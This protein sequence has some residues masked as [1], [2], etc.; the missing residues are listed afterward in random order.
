MY[1]PIQNDNY[2][3]WI[4]IFNP[5]NKSINISGWS[6]SDNFSNDTIEGDFDNF[7]GSTIIPAMSYAIIADHGTKIY[8][9]FSIPNSTTCLY[10]DDKS[11]GNGLGNNGDKL[12]LRNNKSEIIDSVK[13]IENYSDITGKTIKKVN[14][15][16][17]ICRFEKEI[18]NKTCEKYYEGFIPT[19]GKKNLY[20]QGQ[21]NITIETQ[22]S[23]YEVK[24][25]KIL[26]IPLK[27]KNQGFIYDNITLVI[28]KLS[29]NWNAVLKDENLS[30]YPNQ[31][32]KVILEI[33]PK[34]NIA[35]MSGY[36]EILALSEKEFGNNDKTKIY[37]ELSAPDL[38]IKKIKTYNEKNIEKNVFN[39]GEII[40]VKAFLKNFGNVNVSNIKAEFYINSINNHNYMG[41][42]YYDLVSK[43][44][45]YPSIK[46]DT[47]TLKPGIHTIYVLVDKKQE[48]EETNESNNFLTF[49]I[50]IFNTTP[51]IFSKNIVISE[52]YYHSHPGLFNEYIA[53][54]NPTN[55]II[56]ISSFYLTNNPDK[57]KTDQRKIIFPKNTYIKNKSYLFISENSKNFSFEKIEKPD[58]EYNLD[59][60]LSIPQMI[61]KNKFIM[62]NNGCSIALKN[63]FNHTI[64]FLTYG[65]N[66]YNSSFWKGKAINLTGKG[67]ILKRN[68]NEK[69]LPYDTDTYHDWVQDRKYVIGQ[70][71]FSGKT[72]HI[73]DNITTFISPDN[74]FNAIVNEL[75]KAKKSIYLNVYEFTSFY[76]CNELVKNL[77][78]NVSVTIFLEGAPVGGI[79]EEEKNILNK[80]DSN[81]G[82]IR[83]IV[84]NKDKKIYSRYPFNHAK[85]CIIDN[86]TTII[87]SCN[88]VD[89]GIPKNNKYGNREWGIIIKNEEI[90]KYF[91]RIF[92][93]DYN[94][95]R[96]DSISFFDMNFTFSSD[97]YYQPYY[98]GNYKSVFK[99]NETS[100]NFTIKTVISP[101]NSQKAILDLLDSANNSIYIQ[102]LYIY[103]NWSNKINPFV[104]K[105]ID[106]SK[107]GL[108]IRVIL[109]Y[110]P[111]YNDTNKKVDNTKKLLEDNN[112]K[113]RYI[114]TTW[115][116]FTNI[117]NKGVIVDNESVLISSINWNE[118]SVLNNREI[119]VIIKNKETAEYYTNVFLYDWNL[120]FE[121]NE[122]INNS[123]YNKSNNNNNYFDNYENNIYI[124]II[125]TLT[126]GLIIQDWR[127]R[128]WT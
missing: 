34:K 76:L 55:C 122:K 31:S 90:A 5:S 13:W 2:N 52:I 59:S 60:D 43:Y 27:I 56:N 111:V 14:E 28:K 102:Q 41:C 51:T 128:K 120:T 16:S 39:Q 117:H 104:K 6:I 69:N 19:P 8:E 93:E 95:K 124:I 87:E 113:V 17:S 61:S 63:E 125:F 101:D 88:W 112:I 48:I 85:Y 109:N 37:F 78:K 50:K 86:K 98:C 83:F 54:Y 20:F 29:E 38:A 62:S 66:I 94:P 25:N 7:N 72:F 126:F 103:N 80:I 114:Y 84:N 44:Q 96:P 68:F 64:D 67:V 33:F 119:G 107:Q 92:Y 3:E 118:N 1:D 36:I 11:I 79:S 22:K 18:L 70:S 106:K 97:V 30:L 81:G 110:N 74:S 40:R 115:S 23:K 89:T 65:N 32:K 99:S 9:N 77:R 127:K 46:I 4:E 91:F 73:K 21:H 57:R 71:D 58:F 116:I 10:I 123:K 82:K 100:G 15:G 12:I 108:D 26:E 45:K 42:K 24:L 35:S 105:L 75:N 47:I 53:L 121:K 49:K